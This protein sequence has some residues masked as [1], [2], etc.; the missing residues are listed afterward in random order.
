MPVMAT[1]DLTT[2]NRVAR[3]TLNNPGKHNALS[4]EAME[5]GIA[6]LERIAA[7][8]ELRVLVVT[9]AGERSFCSG[10]M[11]DQIQSGVV[12]DELFQTLVDRLA[13][14]TLPKIAAMNGSAYGGGVEIGL[15]C[16]FRIGV[17]G[18]NVMVP[19]ARFGLC[20]PVA[21]I[22]RYVERLGPGPAKRLLVFSESMGADALLGAGYL[23][24][25]VGCDE[26]AEETERWVDHLSGLAPLAVRSMS[27]LCD[28]VAA[29]TLDEAEA[30]AQVARCNA[31]ADLQEG[32]QAALARRKPEF[33]GR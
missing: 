30:D 29:G 2:E 27:R 11:L 18:M 14:L 16:D 5:Q 28:Q 32:L 31:S 24:K 8:P 26:L 1:I 12:D 23:H 19:A 17:T 33:S 4:R 7:D 20:Y 25:V 9:G 3:L 10:V 21:G 22:R 13:E 6:H 15:C